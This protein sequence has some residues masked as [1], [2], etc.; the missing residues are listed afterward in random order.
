[1]VDYKTG[2]VYVCADP[3][4]GNE[5]TLNRVC[6]SESCSNCGPLMCCD[7]PMVKKSASKRK[8]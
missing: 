8:T 1:M 3:S 2:E 7:K 6:T 5:I 4:C